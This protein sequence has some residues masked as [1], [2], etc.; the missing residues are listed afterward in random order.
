M[1]I[2][3]PNLRDVGGTPTADGARVAA[4]RLLRSALPASTD[5]VPEGM[6]WPPSLVVDLRSPGEG[7]PKHPL[8][9][10]EARIVNLP[11]LSVLRPGAV[12][13]SRLAELYVLMLETASEHLVD[14][15]REVAAAEGPTLVHCSAGKDRTGVSI[16]MLL[17][18]VGV[19]RGDVVDDYLATR[20]AEAAIVERVSQVRRRMRRAPLP[21]PYLE[22]PQEAIEAVLD[23][24]DDHTG[25]I[26][27][28]FAC[29]GGDDELVERLRRSLVG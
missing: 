28:W 9:D 13:P 18:L 14:L 23:H 17:R 29:V 26:E 10:G 27:G 22:V 20:A 4:G 16:A 6:A 25:G 8:A 24:W 2:F 19:D 7:E 1:T 5:A 15:V 12:L 21:G 11:L 3:V